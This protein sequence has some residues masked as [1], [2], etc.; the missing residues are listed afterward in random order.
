MLSSDKVV[1]VFV[2]FRAITD[3]E[4]YR[5]RH[6]GHIKNLCGEL[7]IPRSFLPA[8]AVQ[9]TYIHGWVG[10]GVGVGVRVQGCRGYLLVSIFKLPHT[11]ARSEQ[12]PVPHFSV[13]QPILS[14]VAAPVL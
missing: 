4:L 7:A 8:W 13:V 14:L 9:T 3:P 1:G 6:A 12:T 10:V 2:R 5:H 11:G